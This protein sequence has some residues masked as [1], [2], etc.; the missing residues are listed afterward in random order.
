MPLNQAITQAPQP[1][2]LF[3]DQPLAPLDLSSD[4]QPL[5][6]FPPLPDFAPV[7]Q[8][9]Q[10]AQTVAPAQQQSFG[11]GVMKGIS[12]ELDAYGNIIAHPLD[13][14]EGAAQGIGALF[15]GEGDAAGALRDMLSGIREHPGEALG[16]FVAGLPLMLIPGGAAA[17]IAGGAL[18]TKLLAKGASKLT[19][20]AAGL[21]TGTAIGA[22][23]STGFAGALTNARGEELTPSD[24]RLAA[25][26]GAVFGAA[27]RKSDIHDTVHPA[28]QALMDKYPE[29]FAAV[30]DP[31]SHADRLVHNYAGAE[32]DFGLRMGEVMRKTSTAQS[33]AKA[34]AEQRYLPHEGEIDKLSSKQSAA[35]EELIRE[36]DKRWD[37][38]QQT[39]KGTL[40]IPD[41]ELEARGVAPEVRKAYRATLNL[42]H[43]NQKL[44]RAQALRIDSNAD[45]PKPIYGMLPRR[46]MNPHKVF[47]KDDLSDVITVRGFNSAR[48]AKE[49]ADEIGGTYLSDPEFLNQPVQYVIDTVS[50]RD[51]L[52]DGKIDKEK[53]RVQ[54]SNVARSSRSRLA[55]MTAERKGRAGYDSLDSIGNIKAAFRADT[56]A[57]A[58]LEHV[59]PHLHKLDSLAI[60]ADKLNLAV[61]HALVKSVRDQ[62]AGNVHA[63]NIASS[64]KAGFFHT[65]LSALNVVAPTMN[66]LSAGLLTP[67]HLLNELHGQLG[68]QGLAELLPAM[69]AT[70]HGIA[71]L[72][73]GDAKL[74]KLV[75]DNEREGATPSTH[76]VNIGEPVTTR[77]GK[78]GTILN[79]AARLNSYM[80]RKS[81]HMAKQVTGVAFREAGIARGLHGQELTEFVHNGVQRTVGEFNAGMRPLFLVGNGTVAMDALAIVT[82]FQSYV[83][84]KV[85]ADLPMIAHV[86][87]PLAL[88]YLG[89]IA[90]AAGAQG[91]PGVVPTLDYIVE[92]VDPDGSLTKDWGDYKIEHQLAF[93]G[94]LSY[95]GAASR[96]ELGGPLGVGTQ[97]GANP[98][99]VTSTVAQMISKAHDGM[100]ITKAM[101]TMFPGDIRNRVGAV[102]A[103]LNG[104]KFTPPTAARHTPTYDITPLEALY[105]SA[106]GLAAPSVQRQKAK[107]GV[108]FA[109]HNKLVSD[110]KTLFNEAVNAMTAGALTDAQRGRITSRFK[111]NLAG[112]SVSKFWRSVRKA[113]KNNAKAAAPHVNGGL[114]G[115]LLRR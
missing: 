68:A 69:R 92:T 11:E 109:V 62:V 97:F 94:V 70:A 37:I 96:A 60:D 24:A 106:T 50:K 85:M 63:S 66:L 111:H 103:L 74:R 44:Q 40:F 114:E 3:I 5:P 84:Q 78:L 10:P 26:L 115:R 25:T 65:F 21:S 41:K 49:F 87:K 99:G 57:I 15:S 59:E 19:S 23:G 1:S 4:A 100:P 71:S 30:Q 54:M 56:N 58:K 22:L 73:N 53:L 51:I 47:Y 110:R 102:K 108:A 32:S 48:K 12:S 81:E 75:A 52:T 89:S 18:K 46:W 33:T 9:A 113:V 88:T 91:I 64:I 77:H 105:T 79:K 39:H 45:V 35:Y 83:I 104:G 90:I 28:A 8:A 98:L 6:D 43:H 82:T 38:R 20:S 107:E 36:T 13:A 72:L 86:S 27:A 14:A 2:Q 42:A 16:H 112:K 7:A 55:S 61:T 31:F 101:L 29:A 80:M 17:R 34:V 67:A 95:A 93:H 76:S